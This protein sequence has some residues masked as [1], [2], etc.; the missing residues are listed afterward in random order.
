MAFSPTAPYVFKM[1][2]TSTASVM[3]CPSFCVGYLS[4]FRFSRSLVQ[5]CRS[6]PF[7][8]TWKTEASSRYRPSRVT[9]SMSNFASV[10]CPVSG[11]TCSS[12]CTYTSVFTE[13]A[14]GFNK[15]AKRDE[16][17]SCRWMVLPPTG[18]V[19][20][21]RPLESSTCAQHPCCPPLSP[22]SPLPEG[23]RELSR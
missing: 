21:W 3:R 12:S 10:H 1:I 2:G 11:Q 7:Q 18:Q 14:N 13:I 23:E 22:P 20:A 9:T 6:F 5:T 19:T 15:F 4:Y 16:M 8:K 17:K